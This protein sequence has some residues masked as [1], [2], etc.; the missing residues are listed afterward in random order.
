ASSPTTIHHHIKQS[1]ILHLEHHQILAN[2]VH[3]RSLKSNKMDSRSTTPT[4]FPTLQV[5]H[6]QTS[7]TDHKTTSSPP[8]P[9]SPYGSLQWTQYLLRLFTVLT[10]AALLALTVFIAVKWGQEYMEKIYAVIMAGAVIAI[11]TDLGT[12]YFLFVRM[13][14]TSTPVAIAVLDA[15]ALVMC[16]V[17][18]PSVMGSEF[19]TVY[20]TA[21]WAL[22]VVVIVERAASM[23]TCL[24]VW[25]FIRRRSNEG[26]KPVIFKQEMGSTSESAL[27]ARRR[28]KQPAG[29][30]AAM[31]G[32]DAGAPTGEYLHPESA[33]ASSV[34]GGR[35]SLVLAGDMSGRASFPSIFVGG[36]D[37]D[38]RV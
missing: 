14:Q 19:K 27:A 34:G 20:D 12:I 5:Q 29:Q 16:A 1:V 30:G 8:K 13:S 21:V 32:A 9:P 4:P 7:T 6:K 2:G 28:G 31:A 33:R 36:E 35:P 24:W 11:I 17:G 38:D 22:A 25:I 26:M 3:S 37:A 18:I 15:V 10:S 23:A